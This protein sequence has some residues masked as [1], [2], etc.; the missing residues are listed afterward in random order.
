LFTLL[1]ALMLMF[2]IALYLIAHSNHF[3][4]NRESKRDW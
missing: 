2:L 4:Q 1:Y 3:A